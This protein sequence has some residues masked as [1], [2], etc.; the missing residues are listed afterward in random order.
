MIKNKIKIK[1]IKTNILII[2]ILLLIVGIVILGISNTKVTHKYL[3]EEV[4]NVVMKYYH[5]L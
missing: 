3:I 1:S 5:R 4:E 2:P